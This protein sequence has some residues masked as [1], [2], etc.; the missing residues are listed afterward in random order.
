MTSPILERIFDPFF[1]TKE[2]G[3]GTGLGLPMVLRIVAQ[4]NGAIDVESTPGSGS[5]FTVYLPRSGDASLPR[6]NEPVTAPRGHGQRVM[7][8]DDEAA[9]LELTADALRELGYE[10]ETYGSARA[11]LDALRAEP[12]SFAVLVTD[13]Q[14]PGMS[15]E[16]L[17]REARLEC[18]L[19]PVIL[20]TGYSP[21]SRMDGPIRADDVLSKPVRPDVLAAS[22]A[23]VLDDA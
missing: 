10:P 20:V 2:M 9:L 21:E 17:I 18:P 16:A 15:G 1:T 13:L 22:L 8:V 11:A 5:V 19:L 14:M 7:V 23:R 4:S 6:E 12:A 3:V